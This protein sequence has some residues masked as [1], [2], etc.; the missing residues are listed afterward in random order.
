MTRLTK[1]LT[2]ETPIMNKMFAEFL[3]AFESKFGE[4]SSID[5]ELM[6]SAYKTGVGRGVTCDCDEV[7][8]TDLLV[9]TLQFSRHQVATANADEE[10]LH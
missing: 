3:K 7:E 6:E 4:Q 2:I 1:Y 5:R 9:E 10:V 8:R